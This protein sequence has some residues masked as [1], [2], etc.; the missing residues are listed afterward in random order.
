MKNS[1][2]IPVKFPFRIVQALAIASV[3]AITFGVLPASAGPADPLSPAAPKAAS[4]GA[5]DAEETGSEEAQDTSAQAEPSIVDFFAKTEVTGIVDTYFTYNFNEPATGSFTPLRNFDV[6]HN[7]FSVALVELALNK[8]ATADDRIGYRFDLQFGQVAQ[9]FNGD[10]L[11]NNAMINAQQGYVSYMAPAGSGLTID[12]GKFVTPI[13][14]EPTESKDNYNYSR[15]FLYALGPYYHVGVRAAYT[16]NDKFALGGMLVNGW[17]ATGDNNS[18]RSVGVSATIKPTGRITFIQNLL[19]GPEQ[20]D[21]TDDIRTLSDTNLSVALS[22]RVG[23]GF[24]YAYNRDRLAGEEVSWDGLAIY[25]RTQLTDV[26]AI[27][28]RMEWF[29]DG[30]GIVSG[31]VQDLREF[32]LTGEV[33][34]SQGLLFRMEYRRDWSDVDFF[35][36]DGEAVDNQN[37]FTVAFVYSFS[38]KNP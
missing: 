4:I 13:G 37:T 2:S 34:H 27:A 23:A 19:V 12:V 8:P 35:V 7:Q 18:G 6:R 3:Y 10:P 9:L 17:N 20:Q 29:S 33:K 14:T 16:F 21:N 26:F 22:D 28:P 5:A 25:L 15:A 1:P 38:S 36:K 31:A 32:T 30:A 11:D 24:N